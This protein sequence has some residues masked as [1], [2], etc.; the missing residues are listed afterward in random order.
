MLEVKML[1]NIRILY[2]IHTHY[3]LQQGYLAH[4][5]SIPDVKKNYTILLLCH[6]E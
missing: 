6:N 5:T 4:W 3:C 1:R 2:I